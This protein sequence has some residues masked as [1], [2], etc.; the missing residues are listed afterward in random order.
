VLQPGV[1]PCGRNAKGGLE[2]W[3]AGGRV[4]S[5]VVTFLKGGD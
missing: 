5:L 2:A 1:A 4:S 3:T